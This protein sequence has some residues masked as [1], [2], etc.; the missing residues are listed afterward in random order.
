MLCAELTSIL[1]LLIVGFRWFPVRTLSVAPLWCDLGF[2]PN[3]R[4][5][6]AAANLRPIDAKKH[7][8]QYPS[9]AVD[10]GTHERFTIHL[11]TR[12][13]NNHTA[14]SEYRYAE[15]KILVL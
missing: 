5:N 12:L 7:I 14:A 13:L 2:V 1:S 3:S 10:S 9:K 11:M 15:I 8:S 6:K 4:G